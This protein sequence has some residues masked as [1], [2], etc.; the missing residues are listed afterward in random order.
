MRVISLLQVVGEMPQPAAS[1]P[2]CE[3]SESVYCV[4]SML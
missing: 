3:K 1:I 2:D 4:G